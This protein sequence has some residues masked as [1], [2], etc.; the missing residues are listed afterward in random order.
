[1]QV[2]DTEVVAVE[3]ERRVW[4]APLIGKKGVLPLSSQEVKEENISSSVHRSVGFVV[5]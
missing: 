5:G 3:V 2:R 4:I 1:M